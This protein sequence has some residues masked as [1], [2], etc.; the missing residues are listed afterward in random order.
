[1]DNPRATTQVLARPV[2]D[3]SLR[4]TRLGRA[5]D[6]LTPGQYTITLK[7]DELDAKDW[8]VEIVRTEPIQRLSLAKTGYV[9]E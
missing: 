6:R 3:I 5:I 4:A 8:V 1:M 9:P 7:K 2:S